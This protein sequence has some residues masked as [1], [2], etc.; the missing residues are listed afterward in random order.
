MM[1]AYCVVIA[2]LIIYNLRVILDV[3]YLNTPYFKLA[4]EISHTV[5]ML[6]S[7]AFFSFYLNENIENQET[8]N[9]EDIKRI[10]GYWKNAKFLLALSNLATPF[11]ALHA[12][13]LYFPNS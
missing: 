12:F 6:L 10:A 1:A 5:S 2:S 3:T 11:H 8:L 9:Y 13:G 4:T 7:F